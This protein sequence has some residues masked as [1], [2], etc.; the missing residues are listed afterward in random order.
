METLRDISV[1]LNAYINE[2]MGVD[3][4]DER[5]EE[6][7]SLLESIDMDFEEKL[8]SLATL[9]QSYEDSAESKAKEIARLSE[10]KRKLES[11]ADWIQNYISSAMKIA[12]KEKVETEFYKFSFRKADSVVI[13]PE[14]KVPQDYC[15][16]IPESWTPDKT[17]LK[18]AIK[19]GQ[20]IAGVRIDTNYHLQIK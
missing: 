18:K 7:E 17:L 14:T 3:T 13:E 1:Q 15:K 20:E 11:K 12:G 19:D 9:R 10:W 4:T 8:Q 16:H 2:Y 6:I 5:R